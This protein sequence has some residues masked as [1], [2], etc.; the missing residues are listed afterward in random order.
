[1]TLSA[2]APVSL[3]GAEGEPLVLAASSLILVPIATSTLG[4]VLIVVAAV[5]VVFLVGGI[6]GARAR[7]AREA[8]TFAANVAAADVALEQA[9]ATDRGWDREAMLRAAR[10]ALGESRPELSQAELHLVL[11]DDRPGVEEDRAHFQASHPD[12]EARVVLGR[13]GDG[14]VTESVN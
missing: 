5:F 3:P 10:Q 8:K 7:A 13:R 9:R 12:G 11:V 14:W 2:D 4:I 1:V 6:L